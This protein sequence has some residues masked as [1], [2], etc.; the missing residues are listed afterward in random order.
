[1]IRFTLAF[2]IVGALAALAAWLAGQPGTVTVDWRNYRIEAPLLVP[3]VAFALLI[4][5]CLI[6][7]RSWSWLRRGPAYFGQMRAAGRRRRGFLALT[8]GL[9]AV[10][11][12]DA[13]RARRLAQRAEALLDEPPLT[14]LLSAQAAQLSG[15]EAATQRHFKAMLERSET[16]FLGLRGLMNQAEREGDRERALG[17]ARRAH[18]K[19]P[20]SPWA[21]QALLDHEIDAGNWRA[22]EMLL[23]RPAANRALAP[24]RG[25]RALSICR[26]QLARADATRERWNSTLRLS[27]DVH[28]LTPSFVPGAV[29][30]AKAALC[31]GKP[32]VARS[33][34][35]AS[36]TRHPHP[37]LFLAYCDLVDGEL[38]GALL[39]RVDKLVADNPSHRESRVAIATAAIAA[40]QWQRAR[41][42]LDPLIA[43]D[44]PPPD[45]RICALMAELEEGE[46]GK[47]EVVRIW[48][49]RAEAATSPSPWVCGSCHA[50]LDDWS[51]HCPKCR[52]FDSLNAFADDEGD[53]VAITGADTAIVAAPVPSRHVPTITLGGL[54]DGESRERPDLR[55]T[56]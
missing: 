25:R 7:Y 46:H 48:H 18:E 5:A 17:L 47:D 15:D 35:R 26:Y 13:P 34:L 12:G 52:R 37:H 16:E 6:V 50:R 9:T 28:K 39:E 10:A 8:Q 29:L 31:L 27:R 33:A 19:S 44:A 40:A 53:L 56:P 11:A 2:I 45:A 3:T 23:R 36:W 38:P 14:L 51:P 4:A 1:M 21:I 32:R 42:A 55:G 54:A 24:D 22:A 30:L 20:E 49:G 41:K 43:G